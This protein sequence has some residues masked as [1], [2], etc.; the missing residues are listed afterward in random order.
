[1]NAVVRVGDTIRRTAGPWTPTVHRF[2]RHLRD[3]GLDW[4][5]EPLGVEAEGDD[6]G[7]VEILSFI[8]GDV[9]LY[10]LPQYVWDDVALVD[11]ARM[12]RAIHDASQGFDRAGALWQSTS[13]RPD[14]VICHNDFAP[15]NLAYADG[16]V[17]GVIDFDM[18][19]PGSRMWDLAY[20]ATRAVPLGQ[21]TPDGAPP[22]SDWAPRIRLILDS[23][24]TVQ[25]PGA[26]IADLVR[27]A[28]ERLRELADFSI[29][30]AEE[31][32]QPTLRDDADLYRRDADYLAAH[33]LLSLS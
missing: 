6:G 32:S 29:A 20:Y 17:I 31:L 19:S 10:P 30:K 18:A 8:D 1:M 14:E 5:P 2:L 16:R 27:V 3:R 24:G 33:S 21:V 15:H 4:V 23:Y 13:K 9:P 11:G 25:A 28:I 12:L 7:E 22:E 26:S